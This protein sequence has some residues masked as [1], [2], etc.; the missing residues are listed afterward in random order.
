VPT[1]QKAS[2]PV[3]IKEDN[4]NEKARIRASKLEFKVVNEMYISLKSEYRARAS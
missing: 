4:G 3:E 2:K 1:S